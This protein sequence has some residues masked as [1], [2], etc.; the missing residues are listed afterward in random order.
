MICTIVCNRFLRI[1]NNLNGSFSPSYP[2]TF[3]S[4][5]MSHLFNFIIYVLTF[6]NRLKHFAFLPI[7]FSIVCLVIFIYLINMGIGDVLQKM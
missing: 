5:M 3:E 7:S 2:K 1:L 4:L 6:W